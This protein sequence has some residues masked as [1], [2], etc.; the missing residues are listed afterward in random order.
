MINSINTLNEIEQE[1]ISYLLNVDDMNYSMLCEPVSFGSMSN[2][3]GEIEEL[4]ASYLLNIDDMNYTMLCE[5]LIARSKSA[6]FPDISNINGL[7]KISLLN[8]LI[9]KEESLESMELID[10]QRQIEFTKRKFQPLRP[11]TL[12]DEIAQDSSYSE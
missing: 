10:T 4:R 8:G 2:C 7:E 1:M 3:I 5:P 9:C 6:L 12:E 11:A